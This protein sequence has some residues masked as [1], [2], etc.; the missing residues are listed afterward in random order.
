MDYVELPE[1]V[2]H[3]EP[4]LGCQSKRLDVDAFVV[5]MEAIHELAKADVGAQ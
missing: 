5:T 4:Q 1:A 2:A 3:I